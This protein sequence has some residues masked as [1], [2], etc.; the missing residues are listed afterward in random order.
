MALA[1]AD[2]SGYTVVSVRDDWAT[3]FP[4]A[5]S[6]SR[7]RLNR[8]GGCPGSTSLRASSVCCSRS[9]GD[10]RRFRVCG[11]DPHAIRLGASPA[12]P[13]EPPTAVGRRSSSIRIMNT[14]S[15]IVTP[16][17]LPNETGRVTIRTSSARA[18]PT[19]TIGAVET[20]RPR[21]R[22][23]RWT[24]PVAPRSRA[25]RRSRSPRIAAAGPG[26]AARTGEP[27]PHRY[28]N[29]DHRQCHDRRA[30]Q[31]GPSSNSAA[32]AADVM[33]D[34][35]TAPMKNVRPMPMPAESSRKATAKRGTGPEERTRTVAGDQDAGDHESEYDPG[36]A[37][38][39]RRPRSGRWSGRAPERPPGR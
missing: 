13:E 8:T 17:T 38:T 2:D 1:A 32:R 36:Q 23:V 37:R 18:I 28:E 34:G 39:P 11:L 12:L 3:V 7:R 6:G 33:I 21:A 27:G 35:L 25:Q 22:I 24:V 19:M 31:R 20:S 16:I 30:Q 5:A 4:Q 9:G 29:A 14:I 10:H 26:A 15:P